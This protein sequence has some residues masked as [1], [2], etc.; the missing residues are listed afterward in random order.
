VSARLAGLR[1]SPRRSEIWI[2]A[3]L[4]RK[5]TVYYTLPTVRDAEQED[6]TFHAVVL[7]PSSAGRYGFVTNRDVAPA[8]PNF[9]LATD[10]PVAPTRCRDHPPN[11]GTPRPPEENTAP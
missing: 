2:R 5:P 8:I 7:G 6:R 9:D 3:C 11:L 4:A 10:L 1:S